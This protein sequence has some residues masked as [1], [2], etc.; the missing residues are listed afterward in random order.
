MASRSGLRQHARPALTALVV[1]AL[2]VVV[3]A[4]ALGCSAAR[5]GPASPANPSQGGYERI[6]RDVLPS[7]VQID[8]G[9]VT[10]SGVVF[11]SKDDIITNAHVVGRI[12]RVEVIVSAAARPLPAHVIGLF[13]PD[14]LAVIQLTGDRHHLR[15]ARWA[16]S[17]QAQV[18][19][20]VLAMGSPYGLVDSVTQGII[21]AT[22]RT[23]TG[24]TIPGMPP[25]V[26]TN[27]LQTSA[28]INPGNSGGALVSLSGAVLGIPTL[29]ARDP[30]LGGQAIGI[31]FAIPAN[32]VRKIALQLINT[33]HVTRSDRASLQIAGNTYTDAHGAET[34]VTVH[35][36][37]SAGAAQAAG[38]RPG[39][40][41]V[42]LNGD[43]TQNLDEL[44]NLL[45]DYR[46]GERVELELRRHAHLMRVIVKL[47]SLSTGQL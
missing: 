24:P 1:T 9:S 30:E 35:A 14:D 10:G 36:E 25:T 33:G 29:T 17:A 42:S 41:I 4:F 7:V 28:A 15:P 21:S 34:G 39:D 45:I 26:I 22:G 19:Q 47:G 31:G 27:A 20:M 40:V 3:L 32:T 18:G 11:N 8:A 44:E 37:Q 2:T 38:I 5:S 16:D 13:S 6:I 43:R 46:P 12:K 23:V